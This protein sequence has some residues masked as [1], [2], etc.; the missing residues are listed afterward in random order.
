MALSENQINLLKAE[1]AKNGGKPARAAADLGL[2]YDDVLDFISG[3]TVKSAPEYKNFRPELKKYI[4][5]SKSVSAN[6][7]TN[8][9]IEMARK[10]YDRGV[11]ELCQY[12]EGNVI[13][14]LSIRRRHPVSRPP[15]FAH[16]QVEEPRRPRRGG[17]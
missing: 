4:I 12:R 2:N 11:V 8:A 13:H 10:D 16:R 9:V 6:W 17:Q 3:G 15:Y 5:A 7:V 14:L 1:M